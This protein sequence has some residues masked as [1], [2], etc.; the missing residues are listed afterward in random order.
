M[1]RTQQIANLLNGKLN[2]IATAKGVNKQFKLKAHLGKTDGGNIINGILKPT[3]GTPYEKGGTGSGTNG[4]VVTYVASL[5]FPTSIDN[6]FATIVEDIVATLIEQEHGGSFTIN[7]GKAVWEMTYGVPEGFDIRD[8]VGSSMPISFTV[9][10]SFGSTGLLNGIKAWTLDGQPI[11]YVKEAV[12]LN[13]YGKTISID[14][15]R[16]QQTIPTAQAKQFKFTIPYDSSNVV[17][18]TLKNDILMG[19]FTKTYQLNYNDGAVQFSKTVTLYAN[20]DTGT[21]GTGENTMLTVSFVEAGGNEFVDADGNT[22]RYQIALV[23]WDFSDTSENTLYFAS[24]SAQQTFMVD[25]ATDSASSDWMPFNAPNVGDKLNITVEVQKDD[26]NVPDKVLDYNYAIIQRTTTDTEDVSTSEYSYYFVRQATAGAFGMVSLALKMDTIQTYLFNPNIEFAD[27]M[28]ERACLNRWVDNG[29]GTVSFDGTPTSKLF[30]REDIRDTP[31]T[32]KTHN[33]ISLVDNGINNQTPNKVKLFLDRYVVGWLY[34][35]CQREIM[36]KAPLNHYASSLS[37]PTKYLEKSNNT[38]MLMPYVTFAFPFYKNAIG[39]TYSEGLIEVYLQNVQSGAEPIPVVWDANRFL[40]NIVFQQGGTEN[41]FGAYSLSIQIRQSPPINFSLEGLS[42]LSYDLSGLHDDGTGVLRI[43]DNY[44]NTS[45]NIARFVGTEN[46]FGNNVSSEFR[47][48][49]YVMEHQL[50]GSETSNYSQMQVNTG[51]QYTFNKNTIIGANKS[52][53]YNPKLLGAD[54]TEVKVGQGV[55]AP[56]SYDAQ[57]LNTNNPTLAWRESIMPGITKSFVSLYTEDGI[58]NENSFNGMVGCTAVQDTSVPVNQDQMAEY[59]KQN[60]NFYLQQ[61][62]EVGQS[63]LGGALGLTAVGAMA[64]SAVPGIGTLVGAGIGLVGGLL[65]KGLSI[66][67]MEQLPDN[68]KNIDGNPML[69]MA[70]N[71]TK[72]YVDIYQALES[73]L[74]KINDYMHQYGFSYNKL[75]DIQN[76]LHTRK[77][78]DYIKADITDIL[79]LPLSNII[80]ADIQQRFSNGL[81]FW[82]VDTYQQYGLQYEKENYELW[83]EN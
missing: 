15:A 81:R 8:V 58:Y 30:T 52:Y 42:N 80:R 11:P 2:T 29:D 12:I 9:K 37:L 39:S 21:N 59:L 54:Y 66:N 75:D 76:Y 62:L 13:R 49:L 38:T 32:I 16:D 72:T 48:G 22:I 36:T 34:V 40:E 4:A 31:K 44:G 74:I 20:G 61:G 64:G 1:V 7:G 79:G 28:I 50:G 69:Q 27:C 51:L 83:L 26:A 70:I 45:S 33:P 41:T 71:N 46:P 65:Q 6:S 60:K 10:L 78:F 53:I 43:L 18:T 24:Q 14:E 3:T 35:T 67:N 17:C 63:V 55:T 5:V 57:K 19:A 56:F 68:L 23:N 73:D 25:L 77:Y 82:N 47:V